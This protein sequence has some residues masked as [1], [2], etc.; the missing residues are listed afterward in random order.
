MLETYSFVEGHGPVAGIVEWLLVRLDEPPIDAMY[1]FALG[2][3]FLP[4][5][6]LV[7]PA[8][9][10]DWSVLAFFVAMLGCLRAVPALC[11]KLLPFSDAVQAA[12]RERRFTAKKY[13]SYQWRKLLWIGLGLMTYVSAVGTVQRVEVFLT[14]FC[15]VS[16]AVGTVVWRSHRPSTR[17]KRT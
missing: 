1:R 2:L 4:V 10:S 13:D 3:L 6:S 14:A 5:L 9:A 12:W 11:R 8:A 15:L 7:H 17:T 16:G